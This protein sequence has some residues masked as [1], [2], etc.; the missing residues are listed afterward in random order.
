MGKLSRGRCAQVPGDIPQRG[1]QDI[2]WRVV[3]AARRN[4]LTMLAAGVAFYALLALFPTI[5]AVISLWGL[6]FDPYEAGQQLYE[7][8]RFMP[9]DAAEL[10]DKQAQQVVESAKSG[11]FL[12]ALAGLLIAMFIASKSV[13]VLVIGL[14]VVYGEAEERSLLHRAVVL[15][16]LTF[17]LIFMT[18]VSLAF[19][20]IV[21]VAVNALAIDQPLNQILQWLR[22]PALLFIMSMLIALLYRYAP[23]RRSAQWRWLSYGTLLATVMWLLGSGGLSLY[24]RYFSTFSE[25]YGSLGA[26]VALMLWFWLS[27][28]VV[29]FGAEVNCE[30]E[31]QT[32]NDTTIGEAR[33]L[34]EREAFAADTIGAPRSL[35]NSTGNSETE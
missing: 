26:V 20:A 7:I 29:L 6:L 18:L 15:V 23:Y 22:W 12:G 9:P 31:R 30:M 4:R 32:F 13:A 28:F 24:V 1:W 14:N 16:A 8:S 34:G 27:A 2:V 19:I 35:K 25:L 10:I 17:G 11:S 5:A 21:P 3:R 33:P